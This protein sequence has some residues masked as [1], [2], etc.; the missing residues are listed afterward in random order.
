MGPL[1]RPMTSWAP[2]KLVPKTF[3]PDTRNL[4]PNAR[5][6]SEASLPLLVFN[7]AVSLEK[8][9]LLKEPST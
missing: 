1:P 4:H 6:F 7:V 3:G 9:P 2:L 5:F 8:K